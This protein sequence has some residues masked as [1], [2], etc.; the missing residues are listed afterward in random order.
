VYDHSFDGI[1]SSAVIETTENKN[2]VLHNYASL[3]MDW[4]KNMTVW[5]KK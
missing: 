4:S 5:L 1:T 3:G 2:V